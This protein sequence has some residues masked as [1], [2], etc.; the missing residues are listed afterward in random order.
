MTI[1]N[2]WEERDGALHRTFHFGAFADAMAFMMRCAFHAETLDHHPEWTNVYN[3]VDVKLTTHDAGNT[4]TEKDREL[5]R[6]M[7]AVYESCCKP[8]H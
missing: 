7:D 6:R 1:S 3:R 5:A 2:S 8:E 4:V